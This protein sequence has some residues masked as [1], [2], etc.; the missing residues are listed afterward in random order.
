MVISGPFLGGD[1]I[2]LFWFWT[3]WAGDL[4]LLA[5]IGS[6]RMRRVLEVEGGTNIRPTSSYQASKYISAAS[7]VVITEMKS[8]HGR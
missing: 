6:P 1:Q 5:P 4:L 8:D 2:G 7:E 3:K